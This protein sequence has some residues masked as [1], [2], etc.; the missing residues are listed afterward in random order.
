MAVVL[1]SKGV[2]DNDLLS[3][4]PAALFSQAGRS[5]M[6]RYLRPFVQNVKKNT[7]Q[8]N[9]LIKPDYCTLI[10]V[11]SFISKNV[12]Y[13]FFP[14]TRCFERKIL[15]LTP[16]TSGSFPLFFLSPWKTP[17]DE[18]MVSSRASLH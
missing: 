16:N 5:F 4:Y 18:I 2:D 10:S 12:I 13:K 8:Q 9:I 14:S 3:F 11:G 15:K 17:N 7:A 1:D 6:L